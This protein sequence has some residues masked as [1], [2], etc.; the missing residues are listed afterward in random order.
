MS[1]P[2]LQSLEKKIRLL[3]TESAA[4][5]LEIAELERENTALK[6]QQEEWE[7]Q[8][9]KIMERFDQIDQPLD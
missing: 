3:L 6:Q 1:H 2:L 8:L 4:L 7:T 5:R 9:Q